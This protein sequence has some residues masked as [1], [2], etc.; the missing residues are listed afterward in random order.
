MNQQ[1]SKMLG[2][3]KISKLLIKMSAP[4]IVGMMVQAL[5]NLVDTIFVGRG[6]G[7]MAIAGL[8]IAFPIQMLVMAIAQ[9]IGIGGAS[10]ISRSLGA[11]DKER[12]ERTMG[13][14][15]MLVIA[16]SSFT[17]IFGMIFIEP[18]LKLFGATDTILPYSIEYMR[19]ILLGTVFFTFAVASNSIV[20]SEGNAKVAMYTMLIS[21]GLNIILDPIFIFVFKMGIAGAAIAT[22]LAQA[23]TAIYLVFYFIYGKSTL[24]FKVK[25]LKPD[26][27]IISETFI[28]GAS[29][30]ARQV[31]GSFIAIILNN[32]LS[33]YGGDLAIA[34]YG[35]INRLMMFIF[36]PLFGVVQGLQPIVGYNYGAKQFHRVKETIYLSFKATTVMATTGFVFL[37]VFPE[38]LMSIFSKDKELL[39]FAVSAIRIIVFALPLIGVQVVGASMYQAIGKAIPSIVLSMSRQVLFLIPLVLI[40]PLFFKLQGVWIAFPIADLLSTLVTITLVA[41]EFRLFNQATAWENR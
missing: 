16:I 36:M 30:F 27:K 11:G 17:A 14:I 32:T 8:T 20:R 23:S 41:R 12:A 26:F 2:T 13:N 38:F 9:T 35:I 28:I 37:L 39:D 4:A 21:A 24:T 18:I 31:S 7:T 34:A 5:Y 33:F 22:V 25:N 6:V 40:L 3:E 29:S 15:F 19:V 1:H 10:I